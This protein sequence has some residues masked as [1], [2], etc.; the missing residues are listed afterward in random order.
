MVVRATKA[1]KLKCHAF[2]E[3]FN[4][5]LEITKKN[6]TI[7]MWVLAI[8]YRIV[9]DL[10]YINAVSY[11]YSYAGL[12]LHPQSIR[13]I[14]S[15]V[16][17]VLVFASLPK[18][19]N[20]LASFCL[21]LQFVIIYAPMLTFFA[22][23]MQSYKYI[24]GVS[25]AFI[26]QSWILRPTALLKDSP[27]PYIPGVKNY[28]TVLSLMF[29]VINIFIVIVWNGFFGIKS[30]NFE[31][32]YSIRE[33]VSF[34]PLVPYFI[35]W[36]NKALIPFFIVLF[37]EKKKYYVSLI[38]IGLTLMLYM[39]EGSKFT[40]LSLVV[41]IGVYL[42]LKTKQPIKFLYC[43]FTIVC[44]FVTILYSL[45]KSS[46]FDAGSSAIVYA[47]ALLGIRFLFGPALNKF[48]YF[49][50]FSEFS[51][52]WYSTGQIGSVF[53]L[54]NPFN[55]STGQV[56]FAYQMQGRFL[57]S[58][59]NTGYWGD[60]YAQSGWFGVFLSSILL[61]LIIKF[62]ANCTKNS[63]LSFFPLVVSMSVQMVVLNDGAFIS[64]LLTGG[65]FL[66]LLFALIYVD[67]SNKNIVRREFYA[68]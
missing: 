49:D 20:E 59:S 67:T 51:K 46:L 26:I 2:I 40:Y 11:Q 14:L 62:I 38:L 54:S 35:N 50:C 44:L 10:Y 48:L 43:G 42:I 21:N 65:M 19:E 3:I 27:T 9:L 24:L 7:I 66:L 56:V 18:L 12:E 41:I 34:P 64:T 47:N 6:H 39:V 25:A 68:G 32:L 57:A 60:S 29:I 17:Y 1:L 23:N 22:M 15:F 8:A 37:L 61:A 13:Y 16:L 52:L 36:I 58:N 33:N 55:A 31:F 63:S 30:F 4:S 5:V 45:E 28:A 53:R